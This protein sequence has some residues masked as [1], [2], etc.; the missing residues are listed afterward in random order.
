MKYNNEQFSIE[1]PP[2]TYEW[3]YNAKLFHIENGNTFFIS[4][5]LP[6][7]EA[8]EIFKFYIFHTIIGD[9]NKFDVTY[10]VSNIECSIF[11]SVLKPILQ[12]FCNERIIEFNFYKIPYE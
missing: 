4:D 1:I 9:I 2:L 11:D 7:I 3:S 8:K 6:P 5:E 12:K 10:R